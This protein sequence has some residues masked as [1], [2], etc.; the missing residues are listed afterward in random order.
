[1]GGNGI[2]PLREGV[3]NQ[4]IPTRYHVLRRL[5]YRPGPNACNVLSD[6]SGVVFNTKDYPRR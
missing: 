1:L 3:V 6:T 5:R 4:E 2:V